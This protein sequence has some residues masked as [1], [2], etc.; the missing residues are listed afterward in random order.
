MP[1]MCGRGTGADRFDL[2]NRIDGVD[3]CEAWET[4]TVVSLE[5]GKHV[6]PVTYVGLDALIAN[7][8]AAARPKD[9][10]DLPYL[11]EALRGKGRSY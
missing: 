11:A 4:R 8:R 5:V 9:M 1:R 10:D 6:V 2:M 7:K 3:F